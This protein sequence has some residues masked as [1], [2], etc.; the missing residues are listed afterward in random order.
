MNKNVGLHLIIEK[1]KCRRRCHL[2]QDQ[3]IGQTGVSAVLKH[4]VLFSR[5]L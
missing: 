2:F 5:V 4:H 3:L 1:S